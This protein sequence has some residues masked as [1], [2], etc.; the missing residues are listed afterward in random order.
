MIDPDTQEAVRI[1]EQD[2]RVD[3]GAHGTS[4]NAPPP[5]AP[6]AATGPPRPPTATATPATSRTSLIFKQSP[7]T[8]RRT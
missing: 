3:M 8:S 2:R 4:T 7:R 1:D 5:P 6:A